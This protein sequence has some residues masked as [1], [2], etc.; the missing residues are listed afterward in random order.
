MED[1]LLI[2][3]HTIMYIY[4]YI[5]TY[6]RLGLYVYIH[7]CRIVCVYT[8]MHALVHA[9]MPSVS[10]LEPSWLQLDSVLRGALAQCSQWCTSPEMV[11]T[12]RYGVLWFLLEPGLVYA[13]GLRLHWVSK[14]RLSLGHFSFW[15]LLC[16][17]PPSL[18]CVSTHAST[19]P[20]VSLR[21]LPV[22]LS[23]L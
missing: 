9:P 21:V 15:G 16:W 1:K 17:L 10:P 8:Y 14:H 4:T 2:A 20:L 5:R 6:G 3:R 18:K 19:L 22:C 7:I 13:R 12:T 23:D 11:W